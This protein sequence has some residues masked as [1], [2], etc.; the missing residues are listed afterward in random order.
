MK[1]C[2]IVSSENIPSTHAGAIHTFELAR[3]LVSFGHE[4][5]VVAKYDGGPTEERLDGVYIHRVKVPEGR[6]IGYPFALTLFVFKAIDIVKRYDIDILHERMC[7]PGGVGAIVSKLLD[8]P[9]VLEVNGPVL[10]EHI[11]LGNIP[12]HYYRSILKRWR[13]Q[14]LPRFGA[15]Y[16]QT[17]SLKK[18]IVGW[19]I[20]EKKV[21]VIPNGVDI[22]RFNPSLNG[23]EILDKYQLTGKNIITFIGSYREWH[24]I[25]LLI[26]AIPN[27]LT[28]YPNTKVMIIGSGPE[29]N[30]I[31]DRI[32]ELNLNNDVI[33]L[34]AIPYQDIPECI[35]C[36][37]ICVAPFQPDMLGTTQQFG[38]YFSPLKLFEYMACGKPI[39]TTAVG[40]ICNL[41]EDK[42]DAILISPDENNV[43]Q[44]VITLLGDQSM[45]ERLGRAAR[46]KVARYTWENTTKGVLDVYRS[47]LESPS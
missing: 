46:E 29:Q 43:A 23:E 24:G 8:I 22:N 5:H 18:I 2:Y 41:L 21:Y 34:G 40:E 9:C 11:A 38:F 31:E 42:K 37:T 12:N 47:L 26:R 7:L 30:K 1:I 45:R 44:A 19:G 32:T 4:V 25:D 35:A 15:F 39:I 14:I 27:I 17:H 6:Y 16:T 36:A 3:N 33:I 20:D 28:K 13:T 10:E